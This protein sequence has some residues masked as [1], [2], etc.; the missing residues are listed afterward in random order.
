MIVTDDTIM[1]FGEHKGKS[2]GNVPDSYLLS[3]YNSGKAFGDI[4]I[5]L[6][7]NIDAIKSNVNNQNLDK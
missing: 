2:M 5:Y 7:K 6:D 4:K 1:W 3:L